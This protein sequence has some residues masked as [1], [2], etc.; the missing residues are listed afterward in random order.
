MGRN[1]SPGEAGE[2]GV[3]RRGFAEWL[4]REGQDAWGSTPARRGLRARP[5]KG[6]RELGGNRRQKQ[7]GSAARGSLLKR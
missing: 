3:G 4:L 7:A 6:E 5:V 2:G 1:A